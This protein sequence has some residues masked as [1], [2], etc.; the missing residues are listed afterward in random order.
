MGKKTYSGF[1]KE[2]A[3]RL[4]LDA[5]AFFKNYD[6]TV[7]T[8]ETA[9][10]AGK[11]LGATQG[12]GEF[13]AVPDI[14]PIEVD[15]VHGK[16]KG[17]EQLNSWDVYVKAT[18]LEVKEDTLK[19]ALCAAESEATEG[20]PTG[21]MLIKAKNYIEDED[22]ID[23]ITWIGTL[24]GSNKPVII[25]VKN[26]INTDGLKLTTQDKNQSKIESTFYG[27]YDQDELDAP[28]FEI[29]YPIIA[30][31]S[32]KTTDFTTSSND[33][34]V[35]TVEGGT[36]SGVNDNGNSVANTNFTVSNGAV[37]IDNAFLKTL[38]AGKHK[39]TFI[40]DAGNNPKA[41]V[42]VEIAPVQP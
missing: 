39:L 21:Y 16:A 29:Y 26:A 41:I 3:E 42:T 11:L 2:T 17:L 12:G 40:T 25:V 15:G 34:L 38:S 19:A 32:P 18:I 14:S 9:I 33:D 37:T 30:S 28:P 13:S 31:V 4:L 24:S 22:Y 1:T 27:H 36:V 6:V 8:P 7:D 5:G 20:A 23:N 10:A 35:F